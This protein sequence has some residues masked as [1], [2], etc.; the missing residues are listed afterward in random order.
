[1]HSLGAG[2]LT[3]KWAGPLLGHA[4][5]PT[6]EVESPAAATALPVIFAVVI[7]AFAG[8]L[9]GMILARLVGFI[10]YLCGK[11]YEGRGIV[12]SATILGALFGV[13]LVL[14]K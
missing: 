2:S 5:L 11:E 6:P 10:A 9:A 1:M 14:S 4:P 3:K 12:I 7:G 8:L 13:W